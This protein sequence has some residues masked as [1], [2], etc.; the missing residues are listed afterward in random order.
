MIT[1]Q[2]KKALEDYFDKNYE[3]EDILKKK[4]K[5]DLLMLINK[6]KEM[7]KYTFV[8]QLEIL[9]TGHA[10]MQAQHLISDDYFMVVF[11]DTIYPP[12]TFVEMKE[13]FDKTSTPII[14]VHEVPKEEV[15]KYG[16][17]KLEGEQLIDFVEKPKVEDAPS[18]FIWNGAAIL[19]KQIFSYLNSIQSDNRTGELNLPDG[20]RVML[21]DMNVIALKLRPY[22]D[23][24]SIQ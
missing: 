24:G 9:G 23:T 18:N 1:S 17:V 6:P 12:E 13:K 2:Q 4:G 8:K 5:T 16:V 15:Y 22:L 14:A 11:A 3:L 20:I 19:P 21:K 10:V 7:A